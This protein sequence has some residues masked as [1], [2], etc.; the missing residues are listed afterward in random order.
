[1]TLTDSPR[2]IAEHVRRIAQLEVELGLR[3]VRAKARSLGRTLRSQVR[4]SCSSS[5]A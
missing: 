4:R 1:M 2:Q 3:E 5:S